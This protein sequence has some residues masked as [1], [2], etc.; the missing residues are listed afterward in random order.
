MVIAPLQLQQCR[1]LVDIFSSFPIVDQGEDSHPSHT[2]RWIY[3][4]VNW[5][6]FNFFYWSCQA[7]SE[8]KPKKSDFLSLE[9]HLIDFVSPAIKSIP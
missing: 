6:Q 8:L 9:P 5:N 1:A 3:I 7:L 2:F 4:V